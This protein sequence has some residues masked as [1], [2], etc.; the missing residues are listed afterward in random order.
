MKPLLLA[1][2]AL[3]LAGAARAADGNDLRDLRLGMSAQQLP[4][5]GFTDFI[6]ADKPDQTIQGWTDYK[7]CPADAQGLHGVGFRYDDSLNERAR[8]NSANGGTKVG[9]HPVILTML[10]SDAGIAEGLRIVTDPHVPPYLRKKA[11]LLATQ[12]KVQFGD[13]GWVCT[14]SPPG[15]GQ[16]PIADMFINQSCTKDTPSR[17]L[18]MQTE[19]YRRPGEN[20]IKDMVNETRLTISLRP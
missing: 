3:A 19:L 16:E 17:H 4:A 15:S 10:I 9:G 13:D 5:T 20:L 8:L 14:N 7:S 11:F 12:A 1:C 6:C 2:A 18:S